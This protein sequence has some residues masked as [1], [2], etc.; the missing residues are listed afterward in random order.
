[1][2]QPVSAQLGLGDEQLT[3]ESHRAYSAPV[4]N[5]NFDDL[6]PSS[7]DS[8]E[9]RTNSGLSLSNISEA[10]DM[11]DSPE[12]N[13]RGSRENLALPAEALDRL[14]LMSGSQSK[15]LSNGGSVP[16]APRPGSGG[17]RP[18]SGLGSRPGSG[19]SGQGSARSGRPGSSRHPVL[20]PIGQKTPPPDYVTKKLMPEY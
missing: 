16:L 20:P 14:E 6:P 5:K 3:S 7:P 10:R 8:S 11:R 2:P 17:P 12:G 9:S 15:N 1:M 13:D 18:G 4:S 19:L